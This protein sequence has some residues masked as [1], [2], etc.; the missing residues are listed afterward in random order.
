MIKRLIAWFRV[1]KGD[2]CYFGVRYSGKPC[3]YYREFWP[4]EDWQDHISYCRL[5][6]YPKYAEIDALLWDSCKICGIKENWND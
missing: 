5:E 4:T 3:P 6:D 2:Y 1:P